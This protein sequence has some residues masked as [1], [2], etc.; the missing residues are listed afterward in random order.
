[1]AKLKKAEIKWLNAQP[2]DMSG[3]FRTSDS[4]S[5]LGVYLQLPQWFY[6]AEALA[7]VFGENWLSE[8]QGGWLVALQN[9]CVRPLL[10]VGKS[11]AEIQSAIDN[12]VAEYD[13]NGRLVSVTG[14]AAG[15]VA[16]LNA[17]L[18]AAQDV[19]REMCERILATSRDEGMIAWAKAKLA[20][21]GGAS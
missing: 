3:Y 10:V 5:G 19:M 1:M 16:K 20:E 21:L 6:S 18:N 2:S 12:Y 15:Q 17:Q 4:E 11:A 14:K 7:E 9:K 13:H 8:G